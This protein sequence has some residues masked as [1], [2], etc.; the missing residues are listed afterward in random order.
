MASNLHVQHPSVNYLKQGY[1]HA[2]QT[3]HL[4]GHHNQAGGVSIP[5]TGHIMQPG[6]QGGN[7]PVI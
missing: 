1:T 3:P 5:P 7:G 2:E 6:W 4:V